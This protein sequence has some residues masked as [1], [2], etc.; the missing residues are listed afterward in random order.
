MQD[1]DLYATILGIRPPW[2]V[3]EVELR[4][5]EEEVLVR[6]VH[7][8][9]GELPCPLCQRKAPRYDARV[10]RWRHL[11]T[12]QFRTILE[13]PV[14]R[15]NCS[16]HGVHQITVPWAEPGSQFTALMER[17]AIDWLRE[18]SLRAV[19]RRLR[20]TWDEV[21][22]IQ[23]RAVRRGLSR[24]RRE[25]V[26]RIGVDETSYQKRHE[27][28]T[29]VVD[30]GKPRVLYVADG[31]GKESLDSFYEGIPE[32]E[33]GE[34]EAVAMD[35]WEPYIRST[36]EHVPGAS[37]KIAFD[38]FHVARHLGEAVDEVRKEEH[39]ELSERG[40]DR[41]AGSKYLWLANPDRMSEERWEGFEPLRESGLRVAR[42]W[43]V[44]ETAMCLWQ[45][46]RRGW[47]RLSWKRWLAW[48]LRSRLE[49]V[50][51]VARMVRDHLG[52]ILNAIVLRVTNAATEGIN[53]KIQW[54]KRTACGYRNRER[55]RNAIYFHLGGL[56]LY[57][58][59]EET[60]TKA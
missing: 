27:Y 8:E 32:K 40:D 53:A 22:G 39:R 35:M 17:L 42:A 16:E 33:R 23:G 34:I 18:A 4:A 44:K 26:R 2:E 19:A 24:R 14:P 3:S 46:V 45:Y 49:P 38:K 36:E 52:G 37:E 58:R 30:L 12:C 25:P 48:A 5:A 41:L 51:K 55:F 60:H 11:D 50:R 59:P 21:D 28:V 15:V 13:A 47:A 56:D 10:R 6:L 7:G 1:R 31:R 9:A 54:I 20:L 43:A 29:V 57:P